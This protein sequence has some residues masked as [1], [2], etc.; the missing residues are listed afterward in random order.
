MSGKSE[1]VASIVKHQTLS[2]IGEPAEVFARLQSYLELE[3]QAKAKAQ[4]ESNLP[5]QLFPLENRTGKAPQ[6]RLV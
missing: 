6:L 3:R 2:V 5:I 4:A 1:N